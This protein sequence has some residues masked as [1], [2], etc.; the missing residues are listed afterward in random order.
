[1]KIQPKKFSPVLIAFSTEQGLHCISRASWLLILCPAGR[2][3]R[4]GAEMLGDAMG[5]VAEMKWEER[6]GATARS[7][8]PLSEDICSKKLRC[9]TRDDGP[10]QKQGERLAVGDMHRE[11]MNR[12]I[13]FSFAHC[14][15]YQDFVSRVGCQKSHNKMRKKD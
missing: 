1:M 2:S 10:V 6:C 13:T 7:H 11:D 15:N 5:G 12:R 4:D 9:A 3:S 14:P 8:L